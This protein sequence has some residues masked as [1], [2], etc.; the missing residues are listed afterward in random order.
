MTDPDVNRKLAAILSADVVGY[1]RL[2][3]DDEAATVA[4]LKKYRAA[5]GRVIIM[6]RTKKRCTYLLE[7]GAFRLAMSTSRS[8]LAI[9]SRCPR[10]RQAR[11]RS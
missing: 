2:M 4:T 7:P 11:T 5:V 1:G 9:T 3:Q 6:P 10:A 8:G